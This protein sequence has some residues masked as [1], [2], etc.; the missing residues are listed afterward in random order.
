MRPTKCLCIKHSL[1][2]LSMTALLWIGSP[3]V[4]QSAQPQDH[5][6][7]ARQLG[8]FDSFMD[9]HPEIAEQLRRNPSLVQDKQ[10]VESHPAL[11]DYLQRNPGVREEISENPQAFMRQ[12]RGFDRQETRKE[13]ANLDQF[14]DT[15]REIAEQLRKDP[16]LV[17]DKRFVANHPEL[18][19]F[20][21]THGGV[22]QEMSQNPDAFM[23]QEQRFDQREDNRDRDFQGNRDFDRDRDTTRGQLAGMDHFLDSHPEIAEQLR[24][25]P[26][27]V[28]NKDFVKG[29]PDLQSYLQQHPA[30]RQ[31]LSENPNAFMH[32]EQRFD[33]REDNRDRDFQGNRDFDRDRDTTRGQLAS[34]DQFL[35]CHP[36]IAEQLR[37]DPSLVNNKDFVKGHPDLQ[38]YLQQHPQVREEFSE[39]PNAFMHQ[40]QRFDRQEDRYGRQ[41]G[42][43]Q[44]SRFDHNGDNR[45]IA[46]F[47]QFLGSHSD[48]ADQVSKNPSLLNNKEY[49]ENHPAL[50]QYVNTHPG[51]QEQMKQ[52]PQAFMQSVQQV[53]QP[54][55]K[56]A[57]LPRPAQPQ[58]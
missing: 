20:L 35:D 1:A 43:E 23:R 27:L 53:S 6:M 14:L 15:H 26:S 51:M 49:M 2:L 5:D 32:Q 56:A 39:N 9:G 24:K 33:Q 38:S 47:G 4:A 22:A 40:E 25:D 3:A 16:S 34:M 42:F 58:H 13:L 11:Q 29:H 50:Q 36:E 21:K 55:P 48:I 31:E 18:Q 52:N 28:N 45:E 17:N 30:V 7:T 12:E 41:Q 19:E 54:A 46:G 10:F 8:S 57:A 44:N 37:K